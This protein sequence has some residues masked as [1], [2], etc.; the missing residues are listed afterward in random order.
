MY[1]VVLFVYWSNLMQWQKVVASLVAVREL[2]YV[3]LLMVCTWCNPA[4]LLVDIAQSMGSLQDSLHP[5]NGWFC[6]VVYTFAPEKF[7]MMALLQRQDEGH[8]NHSCLSFNSPYVRPRNKL[9]RDANANGDGPR[10]DNYLPSCVTAWH[11]TIL[12]WLF[13]LLDICGTAALVLNYVPALRKC[14]QFHNTIEGGP[15]IPVKL[16]NGVDLCGPKTDVVMDASQC[17]LN[18]QTMV[19]A[20]DGLLWCRYTTWPDALLFSYWVTV[21]SGFVLV[22]FSVYRLCFPVARQRLIRDEEAEKWTWAIPTSTP[23]EYVEVGSNKIVTTSSAA[24]RRQRKVHK[25][26]G[27]SGRGNRRSGRQLSGAE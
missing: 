15:N 8:D 14:T 9:Y 23:G 24:P 21:L 27:G 16:T 12:V 3:L 18:S 5:I 4:F 1:A 2:F 17:M 6:L 22:L 11:F 19:R 7:V 26:G 13:A 10:G 25:T 20:S